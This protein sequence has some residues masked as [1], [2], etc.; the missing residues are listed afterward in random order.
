MDDAH[1]E[2]SA[3]PQ[4]QHAL[5][6]ILPERTRTRPT[7]GHPCMSSITPADSSADEETGAFDDPQETVVSAM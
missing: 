7:H 3:D 1:F 6:V 4:K 5:C 2:V